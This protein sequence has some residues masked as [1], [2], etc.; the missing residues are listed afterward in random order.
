MSFGKPETRTLTPGEWL[1]VPYHGNNLS[2][3]ELMLSSSNV[4]GDWIPAY[5]EAG[6]QPHA[7]VRVPS[8]KPGRYRL[9]GRVNRGEVTAIGTVNVRR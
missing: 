4:M 6:R 2:K 8:V 7:M 9:F 5:Y 1:E 3:V